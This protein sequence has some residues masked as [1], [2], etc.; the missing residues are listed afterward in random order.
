MSRLPSVKNRQPVER[1]ET[2]VAIQE[3]PVEQPSVAVEDT[4]NP[5]SIEFAKFDYSF[6]VATNIH[7][8]SVRKNI[9]IRLNRRQAEAMRVVLMGFEQTFTPPHG[10]R[11]S[12]QDWLRLLLDKVADSIGIDI[13]PLQR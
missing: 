12:E 9:T 4:S 5:P 11:V 3:P 7:P 13:D 6:H 2:S 1:V 8:R 10:R